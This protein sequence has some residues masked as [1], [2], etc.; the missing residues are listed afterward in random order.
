[1]LSAQYGFLTVAGVLASLYPAATVLLAAACSA[2]DPVDVNGDGGDTT[3]GTLVVAISSEPDSLDVHV[4]T[5]SPTFLV[6]EN[7]YD[8]LVEPAPDLSFRPA[9]ATV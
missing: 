3:G 8:T 7:V 4:S 2:G 1:M 5:A 6:L 9:L